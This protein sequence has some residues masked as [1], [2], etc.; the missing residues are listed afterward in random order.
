M[1]GFQNGRFAHARRALQ[2]HHIADGQG[3]QDSLAGAL[4][5][6]SQVCF[7]QVHFVFWRDKYTSGQGLNSGLVFEA[8]RDTLP[9][10][11]ISWNR[12][13]GAVRRRQERPKA[14][15]PASRRNGCG[16]SVD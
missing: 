13:G 10:Y 8:N 3:F 1:H 12:R 9:L 16:R 14:R 5:S 11:Q 6:G 2:H 15:P 4:L 7:L